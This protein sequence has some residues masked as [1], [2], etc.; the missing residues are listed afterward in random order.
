MADKL[1]YKTAS[2]RETAGRRET[3]TVRANHH[4]SP[5]KPQNINMSSTSPSK[6]G[7]GR[8][9][10]TKGPRYINT[11]SICHANRLSPSNI[12]PLSS[13]SHQFRPLTWCSAHSHGVPMPNANKCEMSLLRVFRIHFYPYDH[14]I[15]I[16]NHCN[17]LL[18]RKCVF[19]PRNSPISRHLTRLNLLSALETKSSPP[20]KGNLSLGLPS[21]IQCPKILHNYCTRPCPSIDLLC[22][23]KPNVK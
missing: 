8:K 14:N 9:G 15:G 2:L 16:G 1:S 7:K 22:S 5:Q 3:A 10:R 19:D 13:P 11:F 21:A 20:Q 12:C 4:T 17:Y 6:S 18:P 23:S